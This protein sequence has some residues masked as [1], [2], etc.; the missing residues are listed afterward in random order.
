MEN[1]E[2]TKIYLVCRCGD[3]ETIEHFMAECNAYDEKRDEY[4]SKV[5]VDN[6]K[7]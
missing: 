7:E 3:D 6:R 1:Q 5:F 2:Q 4:M